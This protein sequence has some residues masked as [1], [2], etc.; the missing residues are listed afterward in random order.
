M[1][2]WRYRGY[3][4]SDGR[5]VCGRIEADSVK[6][7]RE[8][9]VEQNILPD[10]VEPLAEG[11]GAAGRW[12][13]GNE[14]AGVYRELGALL[15]A[16]LPMMAAL[17]SLVESA[18][19]A[20][21][22]PALA[23]VRDRIREGASPADAFEAS[24]VTPLEV[25]LLRAG[26][27]AGEIAAVFTKLADLLEEEAAIRERVRSALLYPAIVSTAALLIAAGVFLWLLPA[28]ARM[29]EESRVTLPPLT[30]A[31]IAIGRASSAAF[32]PAVLAVVA[33]GWAIRR[34]W[35]RSP[36]CRAALERWVWQ[37]PWVGPAR[38]ALVGLRFA[39]TLALLLRGGIPMI[40]ALELSANACGSARVASAMPAEV[41]RVRH[42]GRL[43]EAIRNVEPLRRMLAAW[44]EAGEQ[45][46]DLPAMLEIAA[47]RC[48]QVWN[49]RLTRGLALIEPA[50]IL[51]LGALVFLLALAILQ[52]IL[53][54]HRQIA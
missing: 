33:V 50:L 36:R 26:Q 43:P 4:T 21:V 41:E 6:H 14:R 18:E 48:E 52:P 45:C 25:S 35:G 1:T 29:F 11:R 39:R 23:G 51:L 20:A 24:G 17:D 10:R 2:T 13:R 34:R 7:A 49:R 54:L 37:L 28:F 31:V 53:A 44:V 15:G 42:G 3:R 12:R 27:R 30:R 47:A 8:R 5:C 16:G 19:W 46:G 9:L 38:E 40:E 22:A 32:G